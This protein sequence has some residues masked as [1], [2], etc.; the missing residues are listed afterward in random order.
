V[1]WPPPDFEAREARPAA[2]RVPEEYVGLTPG[3]VKTGDLA[4]YCS[5]HHTK[6][7]L[8]EPYQYSYLFAYSIDVPSNSQTLTL[9]DN[10]K[11]RIL[12]LSVAQDGPSFTPATPLYDTL[13]RSEP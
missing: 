7:G 3:Y 11:I 10:N 8:N 4:W 12:A 1:A 2:P 13:D 5:H 6:D 9:P